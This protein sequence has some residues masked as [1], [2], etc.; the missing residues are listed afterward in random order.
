MCHLATLF[1]VYESYLHDEKASRAAPPTPTHIQL[2]N[3]RVLFT[4]QGVGGGGY[5]RGGA[6]FLRFVWNNFNI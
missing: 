3:I 5:L 1:V 4:T 2:Q 6:N